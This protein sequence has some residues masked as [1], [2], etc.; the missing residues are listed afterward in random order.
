ML[1][2]DS[3]T[4]KRIGRSRAAWW[5]RLERLKAN[6]PVRIWSGAG[7]V[8]FGSAARRAT[9]ALLISA[10]GCGGA[11]AP[12]PTPTT[13]LDRLRGEN[14]RLEHDLARA[15]R[16]DRTIAAQREEAARRVAAAQAALDS[17]AGAKGR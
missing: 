14:E 8:A 12:C 1:E 5:G 11:T 15:T 6:R 7:W 17:I 16:D 2:I 3:L 9:I 10:A 4:S 13:E